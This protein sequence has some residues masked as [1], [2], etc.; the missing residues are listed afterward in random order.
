MS[1]NQIQNNENG[2]NKVMK[3][4]LLSRKSLLQRLDI[5]TIPM[6]FSMLYYTFSSDIMN[7]EHILAVTCF[8]LWILFH[9]ILLLLNYWSVNANVFLGY[10]KLNPD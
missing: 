7:S 9:S 6:T 1:S 8:M 10:S 4:H 5:I 2:P 3:F